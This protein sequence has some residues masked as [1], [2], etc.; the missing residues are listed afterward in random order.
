MKPDG[1]VFPN[2]RYLENNII[3][4]HPNVRLVLC[5]H[6]RDSSMAAMTYDD[7]GDGEADRTVHMMMLNRQGK[8]YAYR[9]LTFDPLARSID[10]KTYAIGKSEPLEKDEH[11]P[12]S[13]TL[14][15]AF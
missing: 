11:Y 12:L 9:V 3:A 1:T 6:S 4:P 14:E 15:N 8:S 10:V 2:S 5:G 7:D 13:F